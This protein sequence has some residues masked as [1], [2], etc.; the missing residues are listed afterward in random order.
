[1][2]RFLI[3]LLCLSLL[4]ACTTSASTTTISPPIVP[5][6]VTSTV[7]RTTVPS[8]TTTT[9]AFQVP[10]GFGVRALPPF[11][12]FEE[13]PLLDGVTYAGPATPTNLAGVFVPENLAAALNQAAL[14][15]L[16]DQG[17]VIVPDS[18]LRFAQVYESAPY[19][20]YPVFVTTDSAYHLW[21]L[22][23][24]KIL[25]DVE[26]DVLLPELQGLLVGL[27]DDARTQ[28]ADLAGTDLEEPAGR[29]ISLF[30]A[31]VV[32]SGVDGGAISPRAEQE[33]ALAREHA[34]ITTSPISAFGECVPTVSPAGCV[35]YSLFKPR[36]HYTRNADLEGYFLAMSVLGQE[37]FFV[38][39]PESL[40]LG[41][42]VTR[43]LLDDPALL[44]GWEKVY[45]PT[46]F[47]VGLADDYTPTELA[48]VAD[49]VQPGMLGDPAAIADLG[50]VERIGDALLATREIAI[51]PEASAVRIMGARFVIDS[52]VLD[53][54]S[55]PNVGTREDPR[56]KVSPLDLAA[57]MGSDFALDI[58]LR[59]GEADFSEY[60]E[61]MEK[62][63]ALFVDRPID[64]WAGTV[65]DAWLYAIEPMFLPHEEAFPDFMQTGAWTAKAHQTGLGS[66][67]E[68][69]HDTILYAKQGFA[70][71]G[72][73]E[74]PPIQIRHWVE[75][76][77]V[78]FLRVA[79]VAGLLQDGL[80]ER[81][82]LPPD[83]DE[84]LTTLRVDVLD[85]F[86]R[87]AREEIDGLSIS[88]DDNAFLETIGSLMEFIWVQSSDLEPDLEMPS[89]AD[90]ES[91]LIADIFRST[92][93]VLEIGTG[94]IDRIF[95]IVP[96]DEGIFQVAV[97]AAYS[98][99][100][101]WVPAIDRLTDEQWRARL[102][103][104]AVPDRSA[105]A[106]IT[107]DRVREAWQAVL[108][109]D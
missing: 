6:P 81:G 71:E 4:G 87:I 66:Y 8:S 59:A 38:S 78:A 1:M 37:S 80:N 55:Y 108:F 49:D 104:G 82:L 44:A 5:D 90:Q 2:Q 93:E 29:V 11:A 84:L 51:N 33:I 34:R 17:F 72:G 26:Q 15:T 69:K 107:D 12:A 73:D 100:E 98:Y 24:S 74:P 105:P 41:L 56:V 46:A 32:L 109:G 23:F 77:P 79:A 64:S 76:D 9:P 20:G 42:L 57:A 30:E 50:L 102:E 101:F 95:V 85:R 68:L 3:V 99:Y 70:A 106:V 22:V 63:Q 58:Q 43:L 47:M 97:G 65:Y 96:N 86:A 36:G 18:Y 61:Q 48:A 62:M 27:L 10:A 14:S 67:T 53:Q 31:A 52:Y 40:Q 89:P 45:E 60:D 103:T 16:A 88:V 35:D 83:Q 54:L 75:P 94:R 39:Q 91:A 28:A 7:G 21:H 13:I 92:F 19:G 25:R